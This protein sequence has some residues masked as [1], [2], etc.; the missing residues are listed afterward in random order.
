MFRSR[1]IMKPALV[2]LMLSVIIGALAQSASAK[3]F[4]SLFGRK[5]LPVYHVP[6]GNPQSW[7]HKNSV[8][9]IKSAMDFRVIQKRI[10]RRLSS[11]CALGQFN[12]RRDKEFF[13]VARYQKKNVVILGYAHGRGVNLRDPAGIADQK[14]WVFVSL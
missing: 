7:V 1:S 9:F 3:V 8:H 14:K 11:A 12:Q 6:R 13:V 5:G 4:E 2:A 10:D